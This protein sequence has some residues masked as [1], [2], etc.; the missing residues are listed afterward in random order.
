MYTK[1]KKLQE[2]LADKVITKDSFESIKTICGVDVS[3]KKN[4]ACASAVIVDRKTLNVIES[5]NSKSM[6][7][8]PYVPGLFFLREAAPAIS[9]V[10]SLQNKFDLLLVDG[11]GQLHP[12]RCGFACYIGLTLDKPTIGVAKALLCGKIKN[13]RVLVD[14]KVLGMIIENKKPLFV[15]V[16]HK[17]SLNTA[18]KIVSELIKP[19]H[20]LPEPLRIAD[21]YSKDHIDFK[22]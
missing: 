4:L 12:R 21:L 1:Y 20:W 9:V 7:K 8:Q 19:K 3:Y 17:I 10:K 18:T 6:V 2:E 22:S 15:S 14:N 16:G 11:H 13:D 5:A